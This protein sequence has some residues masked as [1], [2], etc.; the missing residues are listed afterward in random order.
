MSHA[1]CEWVMAHGLDA[2][3]PLPLLLSALSFFLVFRSMRDIYIYI[4]IRVCVYIYMCIQMYICIYIYIYI[5]IYLYVVYIR[6]HQ[7]SIRTRWRGVIGCLIF[8][9][10]FPQKSPM[11]SGSFAKNDLQLK[12]SYEISPPCT[13]E[14]VR[15]G[16]WIL[17]LSAHALRAYV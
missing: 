5:Y 9:G 6:T 8:I 7:I 2:M 10:H 11:I 15:R 14:C 3:S 12:A 17:L 1:T 16:P 13:T 4:Y